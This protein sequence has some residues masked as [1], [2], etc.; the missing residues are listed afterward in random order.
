M[1]RAFAEELLRIRRER[2][3]VLPVQEDAGKFG[4]AVLRV[5][6]G[7]RDDRVLAGLGGHRVG[8]FVEDQLGGHRLSL[9]PALA[10]QLTS[11]AD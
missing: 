10:Q 9:D 2:A 1:D 7:D 3:P 6:L 11:I 8:P 4:E 5:L